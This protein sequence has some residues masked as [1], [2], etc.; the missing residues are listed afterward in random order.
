MVQTSKDGYLIIQLRAITD[1]IE[2]MRMETQKHLC[3]MGIFMRR[4]ISNF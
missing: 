2:E 1:N 3:C 4:K